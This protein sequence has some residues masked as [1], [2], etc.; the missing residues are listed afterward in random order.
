MANVKIAGNV[1]IITSTMTLAQIK[2]LEKHRPEALAIRNEKNEVIFR[3]GTGSNAFNV[4]GASF[5]SATKD[6]RELAFI[7]LEIPA[8]VTD[9]RRYFAEIHGKAHMQLKRIE[10]GLAD[11][12]TAVEAEINEIMNDVQMADAM[13]P[14]QTTENTEVEE[15]D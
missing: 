8:D 13:A 2:R 6:D 4:N 10:S 9:G 12:L 1:I 3:V 5:N 11:V 14:A 7:S 15:N